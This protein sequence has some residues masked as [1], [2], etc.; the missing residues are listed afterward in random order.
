MVK[1]LWFD[2]N[3]FNVPSSCCQRD[4]RFIVVAIFVSF[5]PHY[6]VGLP[7]CPE[8]TRDTIPKSRDVGHFLSVTGTVIRTSVIKVTDWIKKTSLSQS[9]Y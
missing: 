4:D 7:V 2:G 1:I 9:I 8:L 5:P 6:C 3:A